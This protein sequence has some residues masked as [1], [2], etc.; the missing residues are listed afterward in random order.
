MKVIKQT[1]LVLTLGGLLVGANAQESFHDPFFDDFT[2][3]QNDMDAMFKNFHQKYFGDED[4]KIQ[5][6]TTTDFKENNT[7]YVITMNLPGYEEANIHIKHKD[8]ILSIEANNKTGEEKK[9][10]HSYEKEQFIGSIYQSF[11]LPKNAL[12]EKM[13]KEFKNGILNI[14]IPKR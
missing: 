5:S 13:K 3:M 6:H 7:S 8:G 11:S 2:K 1:L 10:K 12:I 9:D 14:T 4:L